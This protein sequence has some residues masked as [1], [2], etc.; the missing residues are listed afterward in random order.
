MCH[1]LVYVAAVLASSYMEGRAQDEQAKAQ[2][3][4]QFR[5]QTENNKA[6]SLQMQQLRIQEAQD[7]EAIAQE[8]EK[9]R[10]ADQKSTASAK[11]AAGEAGVEGNSVAALLQEHKAQLGQYLSALSRQAEITGS[12]ADSNVEIASKNGANRNLEIAQPVFGANWAAL[13]VKAAAQS[14]AAYTGWSGNGY[15]RTD[16]GSKYA[17]KSNQINNLKTDRTGY[18]LV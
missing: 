5:L 15:S 17:L 2:E 18:G 12:N 16:A 11:T 13:A 4:Y 3:Q 1:P 14:Y 6:T 9:A 8:A 10:Q 7:K